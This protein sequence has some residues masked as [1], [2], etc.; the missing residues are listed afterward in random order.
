MRVKCHLEDFQM[1]VEYLAMSVFPPG[2]LVYL[3]YISA[4]LLVCSHIRITVLSQ[5]LTRLDLVTHLPRY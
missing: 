3:A 4:C 2:V 1:D 5:L